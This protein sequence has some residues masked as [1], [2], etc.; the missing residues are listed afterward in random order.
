M[1]S[2][3]LLWFDGATTALSGTEDFVVV[4]IGATASTVTSV[5][6]QVE[7]SVVGLQTLSAATVA[8]L[9]TDPA[10]TSL[11]TSTYVPV[12]TSVAPGSNVVGGVG[13]TPPIVQDSD[14]GRGSE[15][16]TFVAG[17]LPEFTTVIVYAIVSP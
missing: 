1:R 11:C 16:T 17:A 3:T 5:S 9:L 7:P 14:A 13:A 15:T 6:L 2:P 8:V 4:R 12:Q 10:V